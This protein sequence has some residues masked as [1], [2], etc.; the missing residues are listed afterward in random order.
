MQRKLGFGKTQNARHAGL[1][2]TAASPKGQIF[3]VPMKHT[4]EPHAGLVE[5]DA[6]MVI[7]LWRIAMTGSTEQTASGGTRKRRMSSAQAG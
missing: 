3:D 6:V 7:Q 1:F 2:N 5:N 4:P